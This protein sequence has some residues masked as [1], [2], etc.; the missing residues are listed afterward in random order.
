ML[1]NGAYTV[2]KTGK[3]MPSWDRYYE[4][5]EPWLDHASTWAV[6]PDVIE[7]SEEQ[8]D[9]LIAEWPYGTRGAPVWHMH[10][11]YQRFI[12]LA[13][14]WPFICI[15]SSGQYAEMKTPQWHHR[16]E[17]ILNVWS[18]SDSQPRLH[19]LRGMALAGSAYPFYSVDSTDIARH[20]YRPQN[21][22]REMAIRWSLRHCPKHWDFRLHTPWEAN[23][24]HAHRY[25]TAAR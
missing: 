24:N 7:G 10:E 25:A 4:W 14:E 5:V 13:H 22:A 1:D 2:W 16:M 11:S 12:R 9:A 17:E 20:H 18:L 8:N 6:I 3:Q 23:G 19:M 21:T 15:G